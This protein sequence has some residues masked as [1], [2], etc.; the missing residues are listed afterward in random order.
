M[1]TQARLLIF[2]II[3][4]TVGKKVTISGHYKLKVTVHNLL[5]RFFVETGM[6]THSRNLGY[7]HIEKLYYQGFDHDE[8]LVGQFDIIEN[9]CNR[10]GPLIEFTGKFG[11]VCSKH[12][13]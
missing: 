8:K 1:L 7:F 12:F 9:G 13:E 6:D 2:S 4:S 3:D 11:L 5:S 10:V